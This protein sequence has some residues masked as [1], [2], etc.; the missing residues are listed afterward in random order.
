[1][2]LLQDSAKAISKAEIA[3][4]LDKSGFMVLGFWV[5]NYC[6]GLFFRFFG[7]AK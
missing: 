4:I 3:R 2:F 7:F 6:C 5:N 1:M